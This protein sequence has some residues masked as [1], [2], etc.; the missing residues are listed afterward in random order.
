MVTGMDTFRRHFAGFEGSF[1]IIG[2]AAC[3]EW[4]TR[5]GGRFRVTRDIDM[6]LFLE[7]IQPR[8]FPQLWAFIRSGGYEVGQRSDGERTFFRFVNPKQRDYPKMLEL[9]SNAPV[10]VELVGEQRI[11]PIPV[12]EDLS[13]L[14]AILMDPSY[15]KFIMGQREVV[16]GLAL[17]RPAGLIVLKT[18]AWLDLTR[19][20]TAGDTTV[21]DG[22]VNKHRSDVFRLTTILPTGESQQLPEEIAKD[23]RDFMAAVP[24]TSPEWKAISQSLANSGIRMTASELLGILKTFFNVTD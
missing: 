21:K 22:D 20:R 4:F 23:L 11:V 8:F 14:S 9:L 19:R 6:V 3:D 17:I 10:T 18:R 5:L 12:G 16:D 15:Y 7:A 1:V 13:S 2:G 24:A